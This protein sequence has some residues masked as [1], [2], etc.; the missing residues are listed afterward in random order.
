MEFDLDD[1]S[2]YV[3]YYEKDL[4]IH[5]A[6]ARRHWRGKKG[7]QNGYLELFIGIWLDGGSH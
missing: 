5:H 2:L 4:I 1:D 7:E 3:C 6:K